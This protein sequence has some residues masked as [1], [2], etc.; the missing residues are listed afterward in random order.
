[1]GAAQPLIPNRCPS[2]FSKNIGNSPLF[3][4]SKIFS[5]FFS[6]NGISYFRT[7]IFDWPKTADNWYFNKKI[8]LGQGA[9]PDRR[10]SPRAQAELVQFQYRQYSLD[11]KG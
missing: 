2:I 10:Y 4:F 8:S 5:C 7:G 3:K 6:Q 9:I 1:M 11:G